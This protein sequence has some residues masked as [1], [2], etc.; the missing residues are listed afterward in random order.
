MICQPPLVDPGE[1][2]LLPHA[3]VDRIER[4]DPALRSGRVASVA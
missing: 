1:R 4:A 3:V 2:A